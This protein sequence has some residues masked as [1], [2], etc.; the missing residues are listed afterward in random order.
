MERRV[1]PL[2]LLRFGRLLDSRLLSRSLF[3]SGY[4]AMSIRNVRIAFSTRNV[5]FDE[6]LQ[7]INPW[8]WS[9]GSI[10]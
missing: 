10:K 7:R 3:Q 2:D 1:N 8:Q 5:S 9:I 6:R 4:L